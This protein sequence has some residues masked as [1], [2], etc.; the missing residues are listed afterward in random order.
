M[1]E[2]KRAAAD[3]KKGQRAT[4]KKAIYSV[5]GLAMLL[6]PPQA[7]AA[8]GVEEASLAELRQL[9]VEQQRQFE[10]QAEAIK[11]LQAG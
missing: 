9:I 7:I 8:T 4:V 6:V 1:N 2:M 11:G 10:A 3:S 5:V